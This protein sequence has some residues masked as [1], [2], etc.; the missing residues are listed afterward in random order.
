M[1]FGLGSKILTGRN[2]LISKR[3]HSVGIILFYNFPR[4]RKYLLVKQHQG[5]WGF[6]KG[7]IE[8]GEKL[9]ETAIRELKEET[10]IKK[11]E[12]IKRKILLRDNYS[13]YNSNAK[14][15]KTVDYF[16]AE[17]LVEKVKIDFDEIINFKWM[18]FS[19]S[20][21]RLTFKESKKILKQANKIISEYENGK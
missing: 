13:F 6:P 1:K 21:E 3:N 17:S 4:S 2:E 11:I 15:I 16:I 5:H 8:K 20:I 7:H 14:I 18:T 12:F 9:I 19:K 10:G